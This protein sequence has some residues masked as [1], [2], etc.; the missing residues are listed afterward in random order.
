MEKGRITDFQARLE[1]LKTVKKKIFDR[2][3]KASTTNRET[4]TNYIKNL[5]YIDCGGKLDK[6]YE[7]KIRGIR[8]RQNCD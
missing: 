1:F 2:I 8:I 5:E 6:I 4:N 7:Q 3:F